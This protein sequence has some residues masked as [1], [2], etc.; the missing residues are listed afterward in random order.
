[1]ALLPP[2][3]FQGWIESNRH[4]LKPPV[5]AKKVFENAEF[6]IMVVGGP[7]ARKEYHVNQGEE[8]FWM[9]EGDM[10]LK[11][12][13]DGEFKDVNIREGEIFLLPGGVPH[14][15]Q[16]LA[17]SVG[18]VVERPRFGDE[19]DGMRWYCENT[20]C[21]HVL[22]ETFFKVENFLAQMT[23]AIEHVHGSEELRSCDECGTVMKVPAG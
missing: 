6:I 21:R 10:V 9:L 1:M 8:F 19:Q 11:V 20:E 5:G 17:D 12:V 16:R 14:S 15:P 7:N 18:L 2:F 3:D 23:A 4:L 13:D 22:H